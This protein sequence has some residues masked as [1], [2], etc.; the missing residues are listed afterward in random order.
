MQGEERQREEK[1]DDEAHGGGGQKDDD[2]QNKRLREEQRDAQGKA[3]KS[4]ARQDMPGSEKIMMDNQTR[5]AT[6]KSATR[7]N[8]MNRKMVRSAK[9]NRGNDRRGQDEKGQ[10]L[11]GAAR[12][13]KMR[14][15]ESNARKSK[16]RMH[17]P[18]N[19]MRRGTRTKAIRRGTRQAGQDEYI[20]DGRTQAPYANRNNHNV[21]KELQGESGQDEQG[22]NTEA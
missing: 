14:R 17:L 21:G 20:N 2:G 18:S 13:V 3:W 16:I 6:M 12:K 7:R 8:N 9:T 10:K 1:Q 22:Q 4:K 15:H 19:T 5:Y 11:S